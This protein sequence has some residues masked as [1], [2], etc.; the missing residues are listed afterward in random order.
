MRLVVINRFLL[1][2]EEEKGKKPGYSVIGSWLRKERQ[3][4]ALYVC[5]HGGRKEGKPENLVIVDHTCFPHLR[6]PATLFTT[7]E[8]KYK[9]SWGFMWALWAWEQDTDDISWY[10]SKAVIHMVKVPAQ[11]IHTVLDY[12]SCRQQH[13]A[14]RPRARKS[15]QYWNN[16]SP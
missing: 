9:Q 2:V 14:H 7:K 3:G 12:R 10:H 8:N 13:W 6:F 16:G 1:V 5:A 11:T 4:C 15:P